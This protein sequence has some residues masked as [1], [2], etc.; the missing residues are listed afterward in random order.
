MAG[1]RIQ[2][3]TLSGSTALSSRRTLSVRSPGL[4]VRSLPVVPSVKADTTS[5][6]VFAGHAA[7]GQTC[8]AVTSL[9]EFS[10]A[11]FPD[12]AQQLPLYHAL[13]G[14]FMNGGQRAI[15][16]RLP[17]GAGLEEYRAGFELARAFNGNLLC[18]PPPE[19]GQDVPVHIWQAALTYCEQ[20]AML[21]IV[22]PP[23]HWAS[24]S[25][26]IGPG[27]GLQSLGLGQ[28][29]HAVVYY[30][31]LSQLGREDVPCGAVAGIFARVAHTRGVWKSPAGIGAD[32]RYCDAFSQVLDLQ[33]AGQ[34]T[35]AGVNCLMSIAGVGRVVWGARTQDRGEMKYLA[36][37]RLR[38]FVERSIKQSLDVFV[39]ARNDAA[40][41]QRVTDMCRV[42]FNS[43]YR[44][45]A[46]QGQ[47]P[48]DAWFVRCGL[49]S[50]MTSADLAAG[51]I[52]LELGFAPLKP[53][54]FVVSKIEYRIA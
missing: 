20:Q 15:I 36:V 50:T 41:W 48:E 45:G 30:P 4:Y 18:L 10:Q 29:A 21:L 24:V 3:R 17:A 32:I 11:Y 40:L 7:H 5:V 16:V 53:A 39:G 6:T 22:D 33:D 27:T 43:L 54:E 23:G 12:G 9:S 28:S 44:Q 46:F 37:M 14:F 35:P 19:Q 8:R 25:A 34:L 26:V 2:S 38:L 31:R 49:G 1:I 42:F 47:Q 13:A 51:R 52:V